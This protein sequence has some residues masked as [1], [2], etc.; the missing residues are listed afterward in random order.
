M[1]RSTGRRFALLAVCALCTG[2]LTVSLLG[3][4][5]GEDQ[6]TVAAPPAAGT[7]TVPAAP[8]GPRP[9]LRAG[10]RRV[11]D[12]DAGFSV[13]RPPGWSSRNS[14]GTLVLRSRDRTLAIAV[15]ADRSTP[16][17]SAA[18]RTYAEQAIDSLAGYR[19]LRASPARTISTAPYPGALASAR[20]TYSQ[21]G[22]EQAITLVALQR[23]GVGTFTLLAFRSA[24]A[25]G[26]PARRIVD[27]VV[28]T[29]HAE[30]PS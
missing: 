13:G 7:A 4:A 18:P 12:R 19:G 9:H 22:V 15:G 17:R 14:G 2:A 29:L 24:R 16:G 28:D 11:R 5:G 25:P 20:G 10:W 1:P 26:A 21:T 27:R 30:K 8:A 23:R 3:R 6:R